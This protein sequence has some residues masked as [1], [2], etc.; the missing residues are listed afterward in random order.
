M[1]NIT[2]EDINIIISQ[3]NITNN[4]AI[5]L[6]RL[7]DGDIVNSIVYLETQEFNLEKL[8]E[9]QKNQFVEE[10]TDNFDVDTSSQANLT[11]YREIVDDKDDIYNKKKIE[12]EQRDLRIKEGKEEEKTDFSIEELYKLKRGNNKFNSI[13][14]L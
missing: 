11:K 14:V 3:G 12:R 5:E 6:L 8:K 13:C 2:D 7:H 9:E 4:Q 1:N 10:K